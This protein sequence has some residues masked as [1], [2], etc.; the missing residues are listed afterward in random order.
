MHGVSFLITFNTT[1]KLRRD[2]HTSIFCKMA[3]VNNRAVHA[4]DFTESR[5]KI[6]PDP[7]RDSPPAKWNPMRTTA[8]SDNL[9]E[10]SPQADNV[11]DKYRWNRN[12]S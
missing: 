4:G 3:M 5:G 2:T 11:A 6:D 12:A 10:D 9:D 1:P 7:L 8:K